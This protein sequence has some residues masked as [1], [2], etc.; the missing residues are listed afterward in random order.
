MPSLKAAPG[1]DLKN[2]Q[3]TSNLDTHASFFFVLPFLVKKSLEYLP[4][5]MS[6]RGTV[7]SSSMI[8]AIWSTWQ[9][10]LQ[11]E[12]GRQTRQTTDSSDS[13][14]VTGP[15]WVC[16]WRAERREGVRLTAHILGP[17]CC[18]GL[19]CTDLRLEVR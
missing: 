15:L 3:K 6:L 19:G 10:G 13:V 18:R 7:P 16:G 9:T 2:I 14:P 8:S 5:I 11:E 12:R 17:D 1:Y 4:V